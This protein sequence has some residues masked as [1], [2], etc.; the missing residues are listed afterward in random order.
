[1]TLRDIQFRLR[2]LHR[3]LKETHATS[4]VQS[5]WNDMFGVP[6]SKKDTDYFLNYYREMYKK[7]AAKRTV[8]HRVK[9]VQKSRR[10]KKSLRARRMN[11]TRG[12]SYNLTGAPLSYSMTPGM[13]AD[14]YG[15]FPTEI[16]TDPASIQNLDQFYGSALTRGC[17]IENSTRQVPETMGSNKVG[18]RRTFKGKRKGSRKQKG[19]DL[20]QSLAMRGFPLPYG[21]SAPP[22]VI[23]T[24]ATSVAGEPAFPSSSPV[25]S[26]WT[27]RSAAATPFDPS[28]A[29]KIT[30]DF[31][32]LAYSS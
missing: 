19:G 4:T 26:T 28:L 22:N 3:F 14:V 25:D 31:S 1:M 21:A 17:G 13:T 18:G 2:S 32:K 15:R 7:R 23:Q 30:S 5:T 24:M 27:Y 10:V 29:S 8:R 11:R 20:L 12:G 6:I 9:R 16:A